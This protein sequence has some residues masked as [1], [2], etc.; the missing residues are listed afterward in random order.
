MDDKG[1]P[2]RAHLVDNLLEIEDI[3]RM[4]WPARS[5]TATL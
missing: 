3:R 1:R 2:Y 5:E 4:D